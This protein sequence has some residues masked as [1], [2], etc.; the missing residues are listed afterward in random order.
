LRQRRLHLDQLAIEQ[1][2][3]MITLGKQSGRFRKDDDVTAS[4]FMI[5]HSIEM[6]VTQL[7]VRGTGAS[8]TNAILGSLSKMICRYLLEDEPTQPE[9]AAANGEGSP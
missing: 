9:D 4:A 2:T 1:L 3:H 7:L 5:H 6:T 8:D